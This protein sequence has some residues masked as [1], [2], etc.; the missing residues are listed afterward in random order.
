MRIIKAAMS[1][2]L[3]SFLH[4]GYCSASPGYK[5]MTEKEVVEEGEIQEAI[6]VLQEALKEPLVQKNRE[7]SK[8]LREKHNLQ[9]STQDSV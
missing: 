6:R 7:R 2:G 8:R 9:K 5:G 3:H 4:A 1:G